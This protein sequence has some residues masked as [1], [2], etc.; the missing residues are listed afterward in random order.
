MH[1]KD[2]FNIKNQTYFL[3]QNTLVV[4]V[5]LFGE[6]TAMTILSEF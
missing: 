3:A 5:Y 4:D 2:F 6:H 1:V